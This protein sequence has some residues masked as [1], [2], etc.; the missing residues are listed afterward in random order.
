MGKVKFVFKRSKVTFIVKPD[1]MSIIDGIPVR[2]EGE[3]FVVKGGELITD[4]PVKI[5]RIR[6]DPKYN[7]PEIKEISQ[8][9]L[10]AI[11]IKTKKLKEAEEEIKTRKRGRPKKKE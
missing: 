4:D 8:E 7:T 2:K 9:D 11:E 1:R 10:D 5:D 6:R 3:S